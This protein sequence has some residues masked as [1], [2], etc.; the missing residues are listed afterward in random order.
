MMVALE[1]SAL[2]LL[3]GL[4]GALGA[5]ALSWA[6]TRYLLNIAWKPDATLLTV[7]ALLTACLVGIVGILASAEVLR[8]KPLATLRAE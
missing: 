3:A 7:G 8:R 5:L 4:I 6:V 2:G 1:Y